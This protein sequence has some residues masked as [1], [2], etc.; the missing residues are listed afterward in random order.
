MSVNTK[1][2]VKNGV[3]FARDEEQAVQELYDLIYQPD[4]EVVIFFCSSKYD[5]DRMGNALKP[6]FHVLLSVVPRPAKSR[7][8]AIMRAVSP[9]SV[10]QQGR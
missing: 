3:S 4:A 5:L 10:S 7:R 1:L 6:D 9:A 2:E 8:P